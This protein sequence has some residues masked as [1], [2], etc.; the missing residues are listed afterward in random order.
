MFFSPNHTF[1]LQRNTFR[2]DTIVEKGPSRRRIGQG[3]VEELNNLKISD[4]GDE[5]EGYEKEHNWTHKCG[6]WELLY[7]KVLI[8]MY[9]IDVMHQELNIMESFKTYSS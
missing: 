9:N 4:G 1:R 8:L 7:S 2:N 3:I 5:F 6:L